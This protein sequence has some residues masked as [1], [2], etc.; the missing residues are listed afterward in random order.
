M[1]H[2]IIFIDE[3]LQNHYTNGD[4]DGDYGKYYWKWWNTLKQA[5]N[6]EMPTVERFRKYLSSVLA[7]G[8]QF[9]MVDLTELSQLF[10]KELQ[11]GNH[12]ASFLLLSLSV[13]SRL[14]DPSKGKENYETI[15]TLLSE[16]VKMTDYFSFLA[17][18]NIPF[19]NLLVYLLDL[20]AC[21]FEVD[22][23]HPNLVQLD[24]QADRILKLIPMHISGLCL[25]A[26]VAYFREQD[27]EVVKIFKTV[28]SSLVDG[29]PEKTSAMY[30]G[31]WSEIAYR[32]KSNNPF[33]FGELKERMK[34]IEAHEKLHSFQGPSRAYSKAFIPQLLQQFEG[35]PDSSPVVLAGKKSSLTQSEPIKFIP[36]DDMETC[37]NCHAKSEKLSAC[38][39]CKKVRYCNKDCQSKDWS[40]HKFVCKSLAKK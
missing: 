6:S 21:L 16:A 5:L 15:K 34:D 24:K 19:E 33:T 35:M 12:F 37:F 32:S 11:K 4:L 8:E 13:K 23:H 1:Q 25:K 31:F 36:P 38:S 40:K 29:H 30:N 27:E 9:P 22:M 26:K 17:E 2:S 14:N 7:L 20:Q 39:G 10:V 18:D 28:E 3:N